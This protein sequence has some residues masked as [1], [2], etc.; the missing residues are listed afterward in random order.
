MKKNNHK[1]SIVLSVISIIVASL[2]VF[3]FGCAKKEEKE[4]KIGA[5][6]PLTGEIASYGNRAK[7]GIEIALDEINSVGGINGKKVLVIFEDEKNDPKTAV[8]IITKFA[9]VDK[10]PVVIGSAGSTVTLAMTPIANQNKVVLIS[11]MSSS[12]KLTTESGPY[13]FRVCPADDAQAK[14]LADWVFEEGHKK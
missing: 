5:S 13:F 14:I 7:R 9:T 1:S 3:S 6:L 8:S 10:L 4:I 2:M 12:I 11:P